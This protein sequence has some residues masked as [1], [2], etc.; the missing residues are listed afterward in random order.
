MVS[1]WLKRLEREAEGEIQSLQCPVCGKVFRVRQGAAWDYLR[2]WWA[3]Q[4]GEIAQEPPR[5]VMRLLEH[6]HDACEFLDIPSG[7]LWLGKGFR[8]IE[9]EPRDEDVPDLSE[10]ET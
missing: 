7:T 6:E 4:R 8:G 1:R 9:H 5:N 3:Q 2:Y 10:P